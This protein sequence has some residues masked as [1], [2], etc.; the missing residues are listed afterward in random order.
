ME[1]SSSVVCRRVLCLCARA[2]LL[3]VALRLEAFADEREVPSRH[4]LILKGK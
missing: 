4:E 1:F 3:F 2:F